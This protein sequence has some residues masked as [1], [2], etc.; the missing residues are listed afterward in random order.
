MSITQLP[1]RSEVESRNTWN[2]TSVFPD[3]PAW[4][5]EVAA[6][7][8]EIGTIRQLQGRVADSPAALIHALA[9][10][11][12]GRQRAY[13]VYTY[14]SM[15][16]SVDTMDQVAGERASQARSLYGE[17]MGAVAFLEPELL[18]IGRAR[19]A[20]WET[21]EPGL[22]TYSHYFDDL[23]RR[24]AHVR[25]P[26]VEE[27]LGLAG[28]AFSGVYVT[29]SRL[30]D[31]DFQFDPVQNAAEQALPVGQGTIDALLHSP[32]REVRRSAWEGYHDQYLAYK[33]T[34]A[35]NL[36][37]S[38]KQNVL[39]MRVR[40][41]PSTLEM[42][43]YADNIPAEVYHNLLDTFRRH[44]T[45]WQRY[46][47][48]RRR[49][50]GVETLHTYDIWAPL[51]T[52]KQPVPYEQA[53]EWIADALLPLGEEYAST[54]RRGCLEERWVDL[55]P[56]EGKTAGAFSSGSQ[57][58]Y[59]F[60]LMSYTDDALSLGTLAHELGHSM[61]SWL[62]WQTQPPIYSDYS[63]FAAEVAS[64]FHQA[65]LRDWLLNQENINPQLKIAVLE[66]A[67]ANFHRYFLEMPT[68]A[69]FELEMHQRVEKGQG[70]IADDMNDFLADRF[71]EAY[72]DE[73]VVDR[74]RDGIRWAT[75]GHLY[76]DYYV[77]QYATG[78]SGAN[79]LARRV[80]SGEPD[81]AEAYLG[82]L[83]AGGSKYPLEALKDAGVDLAQPEAVEAAFAV[84]SEYVELLDS[85]V[86]A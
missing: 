1:K 51:T 75:F 26:E 27:V 47:N 28:D 69:L 86:N 55:Y 66:E 64:N 24:Q 62:S 46:F 81:A 70:L 5:A 41:F 8:D 35:E 3:V 83:K 44:R 63:L 29:F 59:P 58:T 30:T 84:L 78:I 32:D 53:V 17:L 19:L 10:I 54:I 16:E 11:D 77:Y 14:A 31:C 39:T 57:G 2:D 49:A 71:A 60:I 36:A 20:E 38:I 43:L 85:L 73:A 18:A 67:M 52:E 23:F 68:L 22:R 7:S 6:L 42:A 65:M 40:R 50:L 13:K 45:V 76:A 61:H 4:A 72:G 56:N 25:S 74:Q 82:F 33:N 15:G 34:L 12:S 48:V 80:L 21:L 37:T 9:T 79:A